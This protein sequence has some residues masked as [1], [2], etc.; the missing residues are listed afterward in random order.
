MRTAAIC[1]V[2]ATYINAKCVIYDSGYLSNLGIANLDPL[3]VAL[4]KINTAIVPLSGHGTPTANVMYVGQFYIDL[5]G[6]ALWVGVTAGIPN[7]GFF[8]SISTSTTTSTTSTT[9]T[10]P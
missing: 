7:W 1:D 2:C 8:G 3:D 5:D 4:G 10:A 9:T 6:P